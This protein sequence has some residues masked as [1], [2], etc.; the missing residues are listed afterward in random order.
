VRIRNVNQKSF[1]IR[2]QEW[3]YLNDS[4]TIETFSYIVMEKGIHTLDSGIK[5]EA[6]SFTGSARFQKFFLQQAYDSTPVILTQV[7]TEDDARAVT[8]RIQNSDQSSFEYKLQEQEKTKNGHSTETIGYIAWE[9]GKGVLQ[10]LLF[11]TGLT[12]ESVTHKWS[13]LTFETVYSDPDPPLFMA[14]LQTYEGRDTA[15]VRARNMSQG[16]TE[17]KVEEEQSKDSETSHVA[18]VVGYLVIGNATAT[19]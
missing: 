6:G 9:P 4:H 11:E 1:E 3:D 19:Q 5:I 16:G 7:M 14:N 8:G 17:I 18:E 2:L 10:G 13:D 15:A 12:S